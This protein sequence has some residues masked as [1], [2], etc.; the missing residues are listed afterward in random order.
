MSEDEL[1]AAVIDLARLLGWRVAHF[2]PARTDHGWRTPMQG[3]P[4]FPDLVLAN[5]DRVIFAELKS[6]TGR[7][8]LDQTA[9]IAAVT[10]HPPFVEGVVW[11]PSDWL[12]GA[13]EQQLRTREY[14]ARRAT[15]GGAPGRSSS[16]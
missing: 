16:R 15:T 3:D 12:S 6:E 8:S 10:A 2:R 5:G 9:W 4:G 1:Q 11:R 14:I 7:V 13:I